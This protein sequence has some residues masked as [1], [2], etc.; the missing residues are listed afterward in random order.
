LCVA[1]GVC[2]W[3]AVFPSQD[4]EKRTFA[5]TGL[6]RLGIGC[7]RDPVFRSARDDRPE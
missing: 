2:R 1:F 7:N 3:K 5:F 6:P 4:A